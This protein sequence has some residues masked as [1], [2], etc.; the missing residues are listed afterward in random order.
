M[1]NAGGVATT[2][3]SFEPTAAGT[4][5]WQATYPGSAAND[6][7]THQC[8]QAAETTTVVAPV[9]PQLTTTATPGGSLLVPGPA[10]QHDVA[11]VGAVGAGP[12]ADR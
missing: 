1:L 4:Y 6:P 3:V 10:N 12:D 2:A 8:N 5:T 11:T 7:A 9:A